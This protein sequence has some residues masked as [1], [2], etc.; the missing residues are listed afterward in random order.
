[1]SRTKSF[2]KNSM[3][4]L[5]LQ[6]VTVVTGF[7]VPRTIIGTYGSQINGLVSSLTQMVGYISLVEAG[8][9][10]AAVFA[11]YKPLAEGDNDTIG[12]IVSA[13]KRFYYKSGMIFVAL[14][15]CLAIA[16]PLF[17]KYGG[18]T[19]IQVALLVAALCAPGFLDFFTLAKYRVLLTA[20][21]RNWVIQ[22]AS[23]V[24]KL[25]Y[26]V[27]IVVMSVLRMPVEV[28]Y[29]AAIAPILLRTFLLV[30]YAKRRYPDIDFNAE[31]EGYVLDQR[32]DAFYFQILN[33]VQN[34][35]PTLVVTFLIGDL[36]A[37]S[38]YSVYMLVATGI[39]QLCSTLTN[40]TQATFGDVV[41]KNET[42]KLKGTYAEFGSLMGIINSTM[43]GT[44]AV[45][46]AP[47]VILYT[48]N[49][50]DID[51]YAPILGLLVMVNAFLY[52]LKTPQG[53]LVVSGGKYRECRP[54]VTVQALV[55]MVGAVIGALVARVEGMVVGVCLSNIY[56]AAYLNFY[57]PKR[58]THTR[59]LDTTRQYVVA[60]IAFAPAVILGRLQ[61]VPMPASWGA[62]FLES[63]AVAAA[64]AVWSLAVFLLLNREPTIAVLRRLRRLLLKR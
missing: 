36:F 38:V 54:F 35:F 14:A 6:F 40:G 55:L 56:A 48:R 19:P 59:V 3:W 7:I 22:A 52:H 31:S 51:Y 37:T 44:A 17:A 24:Y 1:M 10:A 9:S 12:I 39:V 29:I 46:I 43:A 60:C 21:Q 20:D 47:F 45:M 42:D 33:A 50:A 13:S 58:V 64:L 4:S 34:G 23:V 5:I 2:A 18:I 41:T 25:L 57:I 49:I 32:W 8:I 30:V 16:Y 53:L 15:G 28:V 63:V 62:W 27:G 11:L 61:I 26:A